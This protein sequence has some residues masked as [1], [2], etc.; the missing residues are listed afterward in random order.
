MKINNQFVRITG[1]SYYSNLTPYLKELKDVG[2]IDSP[3]F[4]VDYTGLQTILQ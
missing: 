2:V 1:L 4:E 3:R